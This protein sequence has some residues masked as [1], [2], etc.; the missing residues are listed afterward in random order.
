MTNE[1]PAHVL[2]AMAADA[3][4]VSQ[5]KLD[6]LREAAVKVRDLDASI[7]DIET[8]L[9]NMKRER[10]DLVTKKLPDLMD[11]A[12]VPGI[13]LE[14]AGNLPA[15]SLKLTPFINA[16]IAA[17]WP[18]EK[19]AIAFKWLDESGNGD[20]IKTTISV[21]FPREDRATALDVVKDMKARGINVDVKDNVMPATL[22]A[23]LREIYAKGGD[24]PPLDVIGGF[25]DRIV[26]VKELKK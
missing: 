10:S 6:R 5:D 9:S 3:P 17:S 25:I 14:A 12:G 26:K 22:T 7:V 18:E 2:A 4:K 16:N 11:Q 15:V 19:R 23:W 1:V 13:D 24:R 20:L 8:R 21:S